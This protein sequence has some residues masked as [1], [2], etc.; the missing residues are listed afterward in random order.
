[1]RHWLFIFL[2]IILGIY[3]GIKATYE[4]SWDGWRVGSAQTLLSNKHWVE[5]G[6][7]KNYFLFLPQGYSKTVRYFDDLY[8][9]QHARGVTTGGLIGKRLH[10][11]HYPSGYLLPTAFLM[12]LGVEKRM[13]LRFLEILFSLGALA[14]L[15]WIFLM[16]SNRL[17]ATISVIYYSISTLFLDYADTLANQPMDELLRF[18]IIALS[19]ATLNYKRKYFNY[20]IWILYFVLA[21]SSYDSTVFIFAWLV[22]LDLIINKKFNWK[23]WLFWASAPILAFAIQLLQNILYL[24]WHNMLLDLYGIFK[25]QMIGSRS[26]FFVSHFK[27]LFEPFGWFFGVKWYL[28]IV[29][30]IL[31]ILGFWF[32]QKHSNS[33]YFHSSNNGNKTLNYLI[34]GLLTILFHFLF[35][36]SLFF[37]QGRLIAIFGGLLVGI[38]TMIFIKEVVSL[39][40]TNT[41]I[42]RCIVVFVIF[43]LISSLWF[44]Q[45]KRIYAYIKMWPNNV[46]PAES[47]N[48]DKKIKNL[49]FGDKVIFHM[50]GLNR[51]VSGSDRYPMA[52]SEDEYYMDAP[53]LS[54]TNINDLIRDLNYLK[55]RSKFPFS[56]IIITDNKETMDAIRKNLKSKMLPSQIDSRYILTIP[57]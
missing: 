19:I 53:I 6:V 2:I 43:I 13:W 25:V 51:E 5:N 14:I 50:S 37:Y 57:Q 30:S 8:L 11:T 46:W 34:L 41:S 44:I 27:R 1:M 3:L 56:A 40:K 24:G 21:F 10:Y 32:I 48:F 52:A 7:F 16:I 28:G 12:R 9:R 45:G 17:V 33:E 35:F 26:G 20:I 23:K 36:P 54:F 15:Y 55:N 38:L 47:I 29:V 39:F 31:G 22:G 42:Q 4:N 49:F 18:V